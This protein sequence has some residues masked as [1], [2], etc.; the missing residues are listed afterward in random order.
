MNLTEAI[1]QKAIELGFDLVGITGAESIDAGQCHPRARP[2]DA[3]MI[4]IFHQGLEQPGFDLVGRRKIRMSPFAGMGL[5]AGG[6][7]RKKR[8]PKT[9]PGSNYTDIAPG[10]GNPGIQYM[11]VFG[12]QMGN[13]ISNGFKIVY[14]SN[15]GYV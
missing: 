2:F 12:C 5:I 8:F 14:Q 11:L 6:A 15:G 7:C 9:G 1:K 10:S 4:V 3:Y 13:G